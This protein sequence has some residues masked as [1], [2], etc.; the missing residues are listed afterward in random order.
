[1]RKKNNEKI[2]EKDKLEMLGFVYEWIERQLKRSVIEKWDEKTR[3]MVFESVLEPS[4]WFVKAIAVGDETFDRI[5]TLVKKSFE[6]RR[7]HGD[8]RGI[9]DERKE[10]TIRHIKHLIEVHEERAFGP[11]KTKQIRKLRKK[12]EMEET[13]QKV[14]KHARQAAQKRPDRKVEL[15][16]LDHLLMVKAWIESRAFPFSELDLDRKVAGEEP[17]LEISYKIWKPDFLH[18]MYQYEEDYQNFPLKWLGFKLTVW[19]FEYLYHKWKRDRDLDHI[20]ES[21]Y[22]SED[23][24]KTIRARCRSNILGFRRVRLLK[25]IIG[26]YQDQRYASAITLALTQ[27]EGVI[28][29]LAVI[30]HNIGVEKIF[31]NKKV[32]V[33][34]H[35]GFKLMDEKGLPIKAEPT[36]GLL[37]RSTRMKD[38]LYAPFLDYCTGELFRE[39][40]PILHGR[41]TNFGTKLEANKKLL[42]LE[43]VVSTL[44]NVLVDNADVFLGHA[45]GKHFKEFKEKLSKGDSEG[46]LALLREV[47]EKRAGQK[48]LSLENR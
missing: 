39:R 1:M 5:H 29:D 24:F 9:Y 10:K 3:L 11:K 26:N 14:T 46:A 16:S 43:M 38:Y 20:L 17:I 36:V 32:R 25:E 19:A 21:F 34:H 7:I 8:L 40:N 44:H 31:D 30:L 12:P 48:A 15:D 22:D 28:W 6:E 33:D 47:V 2:P 41:I 37:I 42:A 4:R 27:V 23:T 13:L 18:P 35:R 45:M